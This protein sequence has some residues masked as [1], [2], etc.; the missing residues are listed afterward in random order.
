MIAAAVR[1]NS[2]NAFRFAERFVIE[3]GRD[4]SVFQR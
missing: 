1:D 3:G 4:G 2:R